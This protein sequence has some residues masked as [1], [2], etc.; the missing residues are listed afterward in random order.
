ML[1]VVFS[2][3]V[4]RIDFHI[5]LTPSMLRSGHI[6][7]FLIMQSPLVLVLSLSLSLTHMLKY[8]HHTFLI[9]PQSVSLKVGVHIHPK[10][11]IHLLFC[12]S[13]ALCQIN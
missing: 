4:F 13:G 7:K 10:Q 6:V 2:F 9:D 12:G 5:P 3:H 1:Q 8:S 11:A